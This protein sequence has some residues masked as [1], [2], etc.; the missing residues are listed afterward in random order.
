MAAH[1]EAELAR[2]GKLAEE[3][4]QVDGDAR[5]RCVQDRMDRLR[6]Q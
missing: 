6:A 4:G 5:D 1:G 3:L 2:N